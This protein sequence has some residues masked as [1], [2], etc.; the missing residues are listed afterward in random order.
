MTVLYVPHEEKEEA[1]ALGAKFDWAIKRWYVPD[2]I[3]DSKFKKWFYPYK[4]RVRV[5]TRGRWR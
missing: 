1:R 5:K 2:G 3:D 4:S